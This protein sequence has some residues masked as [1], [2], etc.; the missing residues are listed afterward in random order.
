MMVEGWSGEGGWMIL[1]YL[2]TFLVLDRLGDCKA[3]SQCRVFVLYRYVEHTYFLGCPWG[4]PTWQ[5]SHLLP[6]RFVPTRKHPPVGPTASPW[7][8]GHPASSLRGSH[9]KGSLFLAKKVISNY[10]WSMSQNL[11]SGLFVFNPHIGFLF[12]EWLEWLLL[13]VFF[14]YSNSR[15]SYTVK[16]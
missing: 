12:S 9:P 2:L 8:P 7:L 15:M 6:G 11:P 1:Y 3:A 10:L 5:S 16:C 13:W 4:V 14:I